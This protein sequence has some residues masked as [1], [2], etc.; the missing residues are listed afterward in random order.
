MGQTDGPAACATARL[1]RSLLEATM[2]PLAGL[3]G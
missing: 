3:A 1:G 2:L